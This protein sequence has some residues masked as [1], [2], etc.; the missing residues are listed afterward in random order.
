VFFEKRER[1][2]ELVCSGLS[3]AKSAAGAGVVDH[4]GEPAR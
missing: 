3:L 4:G 2:F 1:F